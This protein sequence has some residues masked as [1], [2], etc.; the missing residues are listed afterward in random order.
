M[1]SLN[2]YNTAMA[3]NDFS[4][5]KLLGLIGC[6]VWGTNIL[7]DLLRLNCR[8]QVVDIDRQARLK[9]G[10]HGAEKTWSKID[11][12][13]ECDG[14]VVAVPIPDLAPTCAD[15]L[16]FRKPIFSE[17]TL[18]R[19]LSDFNRLKRLGGTDYIFAMHK[20]HYHPGIEALR[21]AAQTGRLGELMELQLTRHAWVEDFHGGDVFW[22]LAVH[23]LTIVKHILG[24]IPK[25]IRAAHVVRD[26]SGFP[27]GFSAMLGDKP[28]VVFSVSGRHC[29]K[30]SG[31]SIHGRK[32]A[33]ELF[34][35]YDDHISIRDGA[36][37]GRVAIDTT[38]PLYLEL[39]EFVNYLNH[40]PAPRCNL[41][42]AWEASQAILALRKKAGLESGSTPRAGAS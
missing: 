25:K 22:T 36:G 23:D 20:W 6:G 7:R 37:L 30:R 15:L 18:C 3:K 5:N 39:K 32:G 35:A 9:A 40:G 31:V 19:S 42:S 26:E 38:F 14:F 16:K 8:V 34:N 29:H 27:V 13:P 10:Q 28:T 33:A 41:L 24:H 1:T 21:I 11:E 17:K 2:R 4:G 12:L